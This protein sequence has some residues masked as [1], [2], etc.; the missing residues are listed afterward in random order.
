MLGYSEAL[1]RLLRL[2]ANPL[3]DL[4]I[5]VNALPH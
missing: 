5:L 1:S 3:G 2:S 4:R